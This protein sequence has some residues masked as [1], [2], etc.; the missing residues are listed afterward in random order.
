MG[1]I[2]T[3]SGEMNEV[4]RLCPPPV[5]TPLGSNLGPYNQP[6]IPSRPQPLDGVNSNK[7]RY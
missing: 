3:R 2:K 6:S 4:K 5:A 1:V 7:K